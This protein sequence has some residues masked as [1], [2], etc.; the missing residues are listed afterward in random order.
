M[1][2]QIIFVIILISFGLLVGQ[3]TLAFPS[4]VPG[5]CLGDA[6]V[7]KCNLGSVEQTI[8]NVAQIILGISGSVTLLVFVV[9]GIMYMLSGGNK[10]RIG[11]ATTM[12]KN[13]FIGLVIIFLS[14]ALIKTLLKVLAGS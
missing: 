7:D 5:E 9:G 3:S 2:K 1:K 14:G 12:L 4:I 6:P 10:E 13:A 8:A 11:K